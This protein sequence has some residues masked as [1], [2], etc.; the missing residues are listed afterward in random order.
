M[1]T[2]KNNFPQD[3][4]EQRPKVAVED[5]QYRKRQ[6]A[7]YQPLQ[8]RPNKLTDRGKKHHGPLME[9]LYIK[10]DKRAPN[11]AVTPIE[12]T[13]MLATAAPLEV[14]EA[15]ELVEEELPEPPSIVVGLEVWV[16]L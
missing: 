15:E 9:F 7:D 14:W 10:R 13:A 12:G 4:A 8:R 6:V 3:G 2:S 11:T 5:K 16:Q 1:H